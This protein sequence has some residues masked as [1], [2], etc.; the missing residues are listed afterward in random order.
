V[1]V[2]AVQRLI[3]LTIL[4]AF[5]ALW[6]W[7]VVAAHVSAVLLP[8]PVAVFKTFTA[9]LV[10]GGFVADL[11]V[12]LSE[13]VA[14]FLIAAIPGCLVGY[15][16]GRSPV[17]VR[18]FDPIF[19][20]LYAVPMILFFPLYLLFFGLGSGSKIALGASFAF[21]P[22]VLN[23]IA[24]VSR[25][26][27]GYVRVARSMGASE[28]RLFLNVMLPA[29]FPIILSG[30]RIGAILSFL[31]VLGGETISSDA[32]LGYRIATLAESMDSAQ[33]FAFIMFA[34]CIAILLNVG[35]SYVQRRYGD[36]P[37]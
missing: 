21:F 1:S 13:V 22:V 33:V 24:G 36:Y 12:T 15:F 35:L 5:I 37:T 25:V 28:S 30:L 7:G 27:R 11:L 26:E 9:L 17:A 4:V 18:V 34:T 6:Q 10:S 20:A 2:A 3:R 16:V 14:A 23:T 31:S 8:T 29:A 19:S 32:G